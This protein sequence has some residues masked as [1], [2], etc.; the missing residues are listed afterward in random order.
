MNA[1]LMPKRMRSFWP[2]ALLL[3]WLPAAASAQE[4]RE[5]K[6]RPAPRQ[7]FTELLR[8]YRNLNDYTVKIRARVNM[9]AIRIPDFTATLF[10]KKPDRFHIETKNFAPLPKNSGLF[11]PFQ[12][13]PDQN[14]ITYQRTASLDNAPAEVYRVEPRD[15]KSPVRYFTVWVGGSPLRI[16]QVES[17]TFRETRALVK[18]S[19]VNVAEGPQA[20]LLPDKVHAR[21][22]FPETGPNPAASP[23]TTEDNPISGGMRRLDQI[24]GEGEIDIAYADWR[25]NTGLADSLFEKGN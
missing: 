17:L 18:L 5:A 3:M 24:S 14:L 4:G 11:N 10:F 15:G 1:P 16:L 21:I 22:T 25:V 23:L 19:Y 20:W 2:V 6:P 13:D 8:P 9:P 7:V 12:F